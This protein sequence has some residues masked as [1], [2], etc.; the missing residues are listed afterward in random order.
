MR[1]SRVS[2]A[3]VCH[4]PALAILMG[5]TLA[6]CGGSV[7]TDS[8]SP[9]AGA[10]P[11]SSGAEA[12]TDAWVCVDIDPSTFDQTCT[13]DTDCEAIAAGTYCSG[14]PPC[15]CP[16]AV[17]N[18]DGDARYQSLRQEAQQL[19]AGSGGCFCPASGV[20]R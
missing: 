7:A 19:V 2:C 5:L 13:A 17:I 11:A 4:L 20:P 12:G 6:A 1:S 15:F 10:P 14:M 18:V 9:D 8:R 16:F 3:F